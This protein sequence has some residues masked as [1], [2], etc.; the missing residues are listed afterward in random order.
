MTDEIQVRVGVDATEAAA[1]MDEGAAAIDKGA[2]QIA[3]TM[4]EAMESSAES[5]ESF[6]ARFKESMIGAAES[7]EALNAKIG[8]IKSFF[9]AF[10]ELALAGF[11]LEMVGEKIEQLAEKAEGLEHLSMVT[12]IEAD[13]LS[14]LQGAAQLMGISSENSQQGLVRLARAIEEAQNPT[15][16]QAAAFRA[17]GIEAEDLK[18]KGMDEVLRMIADAFQKSADN[19]TKAAVAS[20]LF[21]R[22]VGQWIVLL[23]KGSASLDD[24]AEKA[25]HLGTSL[26][27]NE[28]KEMAQFAENINYAKAAFDGFINKAITGAVELGSW[29]KKDD[30]VLAHIINSME[31][32]PMLASTIAAIKGLGGGGEKPGGGDEE[33]KTALDFD[34]SGD[35]E[36]KQK[37]HMKAF[38][39]GLD[40]LLSSRKAYGDQAKVLEKQYWEEVLQVEGLSTDEYATVQKKIWE[41]DN[42]EHAKAVQNSKELERMKA[43]DMRASV[44]EIEAEYKRMEEIQKIHAEAEKEIALS[45]VHEEEAV[46]K[47]KLAAGQINAEQYEQLM[48]EFERRRA[49]IEIEALQQQMQNVDPNLDPVKYAQLTSAIE[50][51][52]HKHA[53]NMVEIASESAVKMDGIW[54]PFIDR[55][56]NIFSQ[57]LSQ[58]LNHNTSFVGYLKQ[59]WNSMVGSFA[60]AVLSMVLHHALGEQTKT[61]ATIM[62]ETE[63][64]AIRAWGSLQSLAITAASAIK[65][66]AIYAFTA[67]AAA[68][69]A[70]SAIPYVG[71]FLAPAVALATGAAIFAIGSQ[72]ASAEGGY[73]IGPH[74]NPM[75]QLHAN[76][77]VL[78]APIA[79]TVRNAVA[80][81]GSGGGGI[82]GSGGGD[83]HAHYHAA[84][85]ESP[86][87]I[88]ANKA[89]L[90][91]MIKQL[92]REGYR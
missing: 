52:A 33:K 14:D 92:A 3:A 88:L 37:E 70:I 91:K 29:L 63:R 44:K 78:P 47:S 58:M 73:D 68:W 48:L 72:I 69:Q 89:T 84:P 46:A 31:T 18:G 87:S 53:D 10:S 79:N 30:G 25:Q 1:G 54:K 83:M 66:I 41:I 39:A 28:I 4:Q 65:E 40:A 24:M 9:G 34:H 15:S 17:L 61:E 27:E 55:T 13:K 8:S 12:G 16:R 6:S 85:G 77:M 82:G 60:S 86:S 80:A 43:E 59:A 21:G 42:A 32:M 23:D 51:A 74:D 50:V 49:A 67:I 62:A 7:A 11:G 57:G 45:A 81:D 2:E 20:E 22:N 35:A 36:G 64:V 90:A 71:P 19:G 38:E 75:T 56:V 5:A 26:N 76:E